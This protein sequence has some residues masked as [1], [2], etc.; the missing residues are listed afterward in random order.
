[1][2]VYPNG[3]R[4]YFDSY[5]LGS[6]DKIVNCVAFEPGGVEV[7]HYPNHRV[8]YKG[9]ETS[10]EGATIR[11]SAKG[12]RVSEGKPATRV[13]AAQKAVKAAQKEL[14]EALTEAWG[15]SV[16]IS[17]ENAAELWEGAGFDVTLDESTGDE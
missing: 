2:V 3:H 13:R 9:I 6:R 1:M 7:K 4:R 15:A 11:G 5:N 8:W 14:R 12:I 10:S 17:P 16:G